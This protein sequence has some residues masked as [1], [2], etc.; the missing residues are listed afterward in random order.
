MLIRFETT[1]TAVIL[2]VA[3]S[4]ISSEAALA[5]KSRNY[6]PIEFRSVLYGLGYNVPLVD[7]PLT[8]DR[9]RQAIREFQRQQKLQVD[10]IAGSKTQDVAADLV[11]D[12]QHNLNIVMNPKPLLPTTQFY[13]S[14]TEAVVRQ[15][16]RKVNLPI[17][18]QATLEVRNKLE[19][20]SKGGPRNHAW[21]YKPREFRAVLKGLGYNVDSYGDA[22][23]DERTQQAIREFQQQYDLVVDGIAGS[24]TQ[25]VAGDIVRN[26]QHNLNLVVKPTP[27]LPLN[28][29]YGSQTEAA[30]RQFQRLFNLP[31]TGVA[32]SDVRNRLDEAAKRIAN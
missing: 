3:L 12:L 8:D 25:D 15:F 10:G 6:T 23:T 16:Q 2:G 5:V 31:V 1:V 14:Q 29:F 19:Q 32:T 27:R 20:A 4:T 26:L 11:K 30:V 18:G 17:T 24:Q 28:Y 7:T 9:T 13:G 22:L 21:V